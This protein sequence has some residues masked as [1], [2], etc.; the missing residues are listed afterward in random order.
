MNTYKPLVTCSCGGVKPLQ[1]YL[2]REHVMVFLMGLNDMYANVRGQILLID[3]LPP[4]SKVFS[5][6]LQE[7]KQCV[8]GASNLASPFSQV[9]F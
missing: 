3:P 6:I 4:I 5:L 9:A 2:Q 1:E 8:V 7:E